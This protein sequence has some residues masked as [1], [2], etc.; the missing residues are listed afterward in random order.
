MKKAMEHQ[1]AKEGAA[2]L[3]PGTLQML[4]FWRGIAC[5]AVV[6]FHFGLQ[7]HVSQG[8]SGDGNPL[9]AVIKQGYLGV[10][11]FFVISG[12]C[13][14]GAAIN[15]LKR[16]QGALA[17][18]KA[19]CWRILPPYWIS[20]GLIQSLKFTAIALVFLGLIGPL[21]L[22]AVGGTESGFAFYFN[23]FTLSAYA[24]GTPLASRVAWS[25]CY[26]MAFYLIV[27]LVLAAAPRKNLVLWGLHGITLVSLAVLIVSGEK[28]FYPF[29]LWPQFGLGILAFDFLNSECR[30]R[31]VLGGGLIL[32]G[33]IV[34]L[35]IRDI[36]WSLGETS[37]RITYSVALSFFFVLLMLAPFDVRL[38]RIRETRLIQGVGKFSY[39]LYLV[40]FP[41]ITAVVFLLPSHASAAWLIALFPLPLLVG[42]WFSIVAERPFCRALQPKRLPIAEIANQPEKLLPT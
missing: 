2:R 34:F 17:F 42:W 8:G 16:R 30:K 36:P 5:L 28:V 41:I 19:R 20:L 15:T 25:L 40:H 35:F 13:I 37:S 12:Y 31:A 4:D 23:N 7:W 6:L 29:D 21:H 26:E 24:M 11:L 18:L 32:T 1:G 27:T 33:L 38:S 22:P 14:A 9:F 10:Q 39:S 3:R